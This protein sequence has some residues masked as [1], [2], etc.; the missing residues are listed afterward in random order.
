MIDTHCHLTYPR[1]YEQIDTVLAAAADAGVDRMITVGTSPD[2]SRIAADLAQRCDHVFATVGIPPHDA[3][4]YRDRAAVVEAI[5]SLATHPKVVAVGEMGL[6]RHYPDP[7]LSDQRRLL[8]WQL[9]AVAESD[10]PVVIHNRQATD[11]MLTILRASGLAPQRF[12]FHCFTGIAAELD[13][14]LDF[15]AAVGFTGITTFKNAVEVAEG[16]ARTPLDRILIETDSPYLAPEPHRKVRPNQPCYLPA[17]AR[18]IAARRGL[19]EQQ[20]VS[21]V[22]ANAERLFR[23]PKVA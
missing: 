23:L 16:A 4:E 1:L 6:D 2:D 19:D 12:I 7:P 20:F 17:I 5:Q 15:G 18:F 21:A 14:I 11:E 9:E 10:L 22:D 13:A 8:E 3:A